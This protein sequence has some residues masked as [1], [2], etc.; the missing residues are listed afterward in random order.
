[1]L[2]TENL[3]RPS[4][5]QRRLILAIHRF[6][7]CT[8]IKDPN[9]AA[10]LTSLRRASPPTRVRSFAV[11]A[12][13]PSPGRVAYGGGDAAA[14]ERRVRQRSV[15]KDNAVTLHQDLLCLDGVRGSKSSRKNN[16]PTDCIT[17]VL[18]S[19]EAST[20]SCSS[21]TSFWIELKKPSINRNCFTFL[22]HHLHDAH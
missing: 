13:S 7:R 9:A 3:A 20:W 11:A 10:C 1:M 12:M 5:N 8:Q 4:R 2:T 19:T 17:E 16:I 18:E 14:T 6:H 15:Y 22:N 21:A